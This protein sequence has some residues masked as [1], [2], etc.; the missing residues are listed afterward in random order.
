MENEEKK[1]ECCGDKEKCENCMH[2]HCHNWRKCHM[3]KWIV[4]AVALIVAFCIGTQFGEMH[5]NYRGERFDRGGMMNW[6]YGQWKDNNVYDE[7]S[8]EV[9]VDVTKAP[10]TPT[11]TT[12][13]Q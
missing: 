3:I 8:S 7:A 5:G 6:G 9:T 12:P 4:V 13:K 11:T 2:H 10:T 1:V